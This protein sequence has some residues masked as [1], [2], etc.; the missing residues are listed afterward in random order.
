[1]FQMS[2]DEGNPDS[3]VYIVSKVVV[4]LSGGSTDNDGVGVSEYT[5]DSISGCP[6]VF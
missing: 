6:P 4:P 1:M 2:E 3:G 5:V